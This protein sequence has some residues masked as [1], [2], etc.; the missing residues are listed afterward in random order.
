M[1][2]E[3]LFDP[4]PEKLRLTAGEIH[5]F[6]ALLDQ[7]SGQ[8]DRLTRTLSEDE[9]AR[10]G[11]FHF[12]KDM[13]RFV[14][15]RGTL[16]EILGQMLDVEPSDLNFSYGPNGKPQLTGSLQKSLPH[17][18]LA[19]SDS[20]AIYAISQA[21]E[22]GVDIECIRHIGEA[23]R[24]TRRFFLEHEQAQWH[25]LPKDA[26]ME[27]FFN[28]WVRKEARLKMCGA[29]IGEISAQTADCIGEQTSMHL[30]SP[31]YNYTAAVAARCHGLRI[32]TWKW[33]EAKATKT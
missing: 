33:P 6:C 14:A 23:E 22:I 28:C 30:L 20:L 7:P 4:A 10:A 24:I 9:R 1:S 15:G 3:I 18:N 16:R 11:R 2:P 17:F 12:Q 26:R 19:H 31:A 27:F 5:V 21:F 8:I 29:G 32:N 25:S 13:N